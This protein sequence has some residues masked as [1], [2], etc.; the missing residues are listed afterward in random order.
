[1]LGSV[2]AKIKNYGDLGENNIHQNNLILISL[3]N[4]C[5][6]QSIYRIVLHCWS[7]SNSQSIHSRHGY[8]I[9]WYFYRTHNHQRHHRIEQWPQI[10][11]DEG[12]R[13]VLHVQRLPN[14]FPEEA[15]QKLSG[16]LR[17]SELIHAKR[18]CS[19]GEVLH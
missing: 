3:I 7:E 11:F 16:I 2:Q 6:S 18:N 12:K 1:M 14:L 9:T 4:C 13:P 19:I 5:F 17:L 8:D 15:F 10:L